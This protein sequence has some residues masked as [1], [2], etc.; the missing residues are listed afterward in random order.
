V[1]PIGGIVQ[2][3]AQFDTF[4]IDTNTMLTRECINTLAMSLSLVLSW[5]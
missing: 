5:S 1:H 4:L 3:I 2:A